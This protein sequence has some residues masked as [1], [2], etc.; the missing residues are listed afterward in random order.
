MLERLNK[1]ISRRDFLWGMMVAPWLVREYF[2]NLGEYQT[3]WNGL[4]TRL[5]KEIGRYQTYFAPSSEVAI[6]LLD[7]QTGAH[8]SLNG[9]EP[10]EPG[11]VIN[12]FVLY[13]LVKDFKLGL[14]PYEPLAEE[15][16][17]AIGESNAAKAKDLLE[18]WVGGGSVRAGIERVNNLIQSLGLKTSLIDHPP[19]FG[20]RNGAN[21]MTTNEAVEVITKLYHNEIFNDQSWTDF[22]IQRLTEGKPGLNIYI[23]LYTRYLPGVRVAH[24]VGYFPDSLGEM[25]GDT[26]LVLIDTPRGEI[27]YA[28]AILS[29]GNVTS[30]PDK[31]SF[32][33]NGWFTWRVSRAVYEFFRDQYLT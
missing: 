22:A 16:R 7:L 10:Y 12:Q 15:I 20:P 25:D 11:C 8:L 9:D 32:V 19:A 24:K 3:E 1:E 13:E 2:N 33:Y 31:P 4:E 6:S 28:M 26:G 5:A 23:G 18:H 17:L 30:P 14:Y 21:L 27:A 29:R